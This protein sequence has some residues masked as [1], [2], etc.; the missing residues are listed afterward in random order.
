M[1]FLT[2]E[3]FNERK[4][5]RQ[6]IKAWRDVPTNMIHRIEAV[7]EITTQRGQAKV[8]SLENVKGEKYKAFTTSVLDRDLEDFNWSNTCWYIK[9][10]GLKQSEKSGNSYYA[11]ELVKSEF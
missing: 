2:E 8:V 10:L 5:E 11:Y 9:S 4:S 7:E 1:E 6:S 3:Q